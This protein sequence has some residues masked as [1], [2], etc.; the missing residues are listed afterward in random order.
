LYRDEREAFEGY[1]EENDRSSS[2]EK[3]RKRQ[4][5][6]FVCQNWV[7]ENI[8]SDFPA[9]GGEEKELNQECTLRGS[10]LD[11]VDDSLGLQYSSSNGNCI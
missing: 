5:V 9:G 6:R 1:K 2:L 3:N 8:P 11:L 4:T 7:H 10:V